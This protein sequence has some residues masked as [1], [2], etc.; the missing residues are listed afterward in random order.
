[1]QL[2]QNLKQTALCC[3]RSHGRTTSC[4]W[5]FLCRHDVTLRNNQWAQLH[6]KAQLK[7][8]LYKTIT[9]G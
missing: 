4:A 1:M 8:K 7:K 2:K 5:S 9:C 3:G 6:I